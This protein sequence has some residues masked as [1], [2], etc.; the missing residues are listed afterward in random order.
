MKKVHFLYAL[1]VK[2]SVYSMKQKQAHNIPCCGRHQKIPKAKQL[3]GTLITGLW[4]TFALWVNPSPKQ[5]QTPSPNACNHNVFSLYHSIWLSVCW[6]QQ[7]PKRVWLTP[8]SLPL[9]F[10]FTSLN[11]APQIW[12]ACTTWTKCPLGPWCRQLKLP[13]DCVLCSPSCTSYGLRR[14]AAMGCKCCG[15]LCGAAC[16]WQTGRRSEERQRQAAVRK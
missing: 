14:P 5:N 4:H 7:E 2:A 6:P 16:E 9:V 3:T 8:N 15:D 11:N 12:R 1:F 10:C 13:P